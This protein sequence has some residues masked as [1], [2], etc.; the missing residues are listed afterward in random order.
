[1]SLLRVKDLQ[2]VLSEMN[3]EAV[4][5]I[6]I[7]VSTSTGDE[8]QRAF[9]TELFGWQ[10]NSGMPVQPKDDFNVSLLLGGELNQ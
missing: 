1:M 7:D 4:I 10:G 5:T 2:G 6:S 8:F 9:G 3:P